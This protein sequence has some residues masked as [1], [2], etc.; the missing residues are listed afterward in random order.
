MS[1]A[2]K[3]KKRSL[4]E[5]IDNLLS[6]SLSDKLKFSI[7]A[8]LSMALAYLIPISQGWNQASTAAITV[9]LIAAMGNLH[10]SKP[11]GCQ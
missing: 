6:F 9:M 1:T 8:S 7:K 2:V 4:G 11:Y 3:E 5:M 10:Y